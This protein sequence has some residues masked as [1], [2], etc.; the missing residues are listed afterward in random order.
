MKL[1]I[2]SAQRRDGGA[3]WTVVGGGIVASIVSPSVILFMCFGVF[4]AAL[5]SEYGWSLGAISIGATIISLVVAVVAPCQGWLID[6]LGSRLPLLVSFPVF[7]ACVS[8][9]SLLPSN[10]K[11]FYLACACLPIAALGLWPPSFMRMVSTWF[12]RKLG[13]ALGLMNV[14]PGI[15]TTLLPFLVGLAIVTGGWRHAYLLLGIAIVAI[16]L[17]TTYATL[18]ER[19]DTASQ[20]RAVLNVE[21]HALRQA[22]TSRPFWLISMSFLALGFISSG[23]IVHQL[24]ILTEHGLDRRSALGAQAVFGASSIVGRILVGWLLDRV[25]VTR[26]MPFLMLIVIGVMVNYALTTPTWLLFPAVAAFGLVIGAEF[27]VCGLAIRRYHGM[28]H[29]GAIYGFVFAMFQVGG[30]LGAFTF[31]TMHD[32]TGSYFAPLACAVVLAIG[33]GLAFLLLGRYQFVARQEDH[34]EGAVNVP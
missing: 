21:G 28:R 23:V 1:E 17:P 19:R 6:R 25:H 12:D 18:R 27:D 20:R 29:F 24:D 7:G 5:R 10:I 26:L 31:G 4:A 34:R 13:L 33:A 8:A 11:V 3:G 32:R 22:L 15:G 16:G 14:G 9:M 30:A 2:D